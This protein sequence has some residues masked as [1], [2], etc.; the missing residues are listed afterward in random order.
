[1]TNAAIIL[2]STSTTRQR[3]LQ[4]AGVVFDAISPKVDETALVESNPHWPQEEIAIKLAK[5]KALAISQ[6]RPDGIVIG[7]DQTMHHGDRILSKPQSINEAREGLRALAGA[8]HLLHT[9][10]VLAR[11]GKIVWETMEKAE[12][13]MR[14]FSNE[15]LEA[16]IA[17]TDSAVLLS[18]GHYRLE[19][20]GI[21]LFHTITGNYFSILG[22]PLLPLLQALRDQGALAT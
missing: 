1:M 11:H 17:D 6:N 10:V 14:D 18:A 13:T 8:T 9:S 3:L 15:F 19:E 22:L 7:A 2:A 21:Q 16:Y 20:N 4:N 5:A 12:L